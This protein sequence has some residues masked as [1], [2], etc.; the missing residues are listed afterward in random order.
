MTSSEYSL[1]ITMPTE[2]K[3]WPE[4]R[5]AGFELQ[6]DPWPILGLLAVTHSCFFST[7]KIIIFLYFPVLLQIQN[8]KM[9]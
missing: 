1:L 2:T 3:H 4:V 8:L 5:K 6:P 9:S 7:N